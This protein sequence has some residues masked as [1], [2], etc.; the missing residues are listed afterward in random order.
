MRRNARLHPPFES[1]LKRFAVRKNLF[2]EVNFYGDI[3]NL[4]EHENRKEDVDIFE[5]DAEIDE[6][7]TEIHPVDTNTCLLNSHNDNHTNSN[8]VEEHKFVFDDHDSYSSVL[9]Y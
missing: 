1:E 3:M 9:F 7:F 5:D 4:E 2:P 8:S 6:E